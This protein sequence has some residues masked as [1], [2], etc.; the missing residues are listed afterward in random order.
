[1]RLKI[2][3]LPILCL[4]AQWAT[5]AGALEDEFTTFGLSVHPKMEQLD[6]VLKTAGGREFKLGPQLRKISGPHWQVSYFV[7][8]IDRLPNPTELV[9]HYAVIVRAHG[10]DVRY[11]G[12][13]DLDA[14]LVMPDGG[15]EV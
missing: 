14:T 9:D 1:M 4:C 6:Q 11:R 2:G 8:D 13:Q 5:L 15:A 10:G 12:R 7:K 3:V